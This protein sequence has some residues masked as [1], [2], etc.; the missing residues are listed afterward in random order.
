MFPEVQWGDGM[1]GL[2]WECL[3]LE[4]QGTNCAGKR[5]EPALREKWQLLLKNAVVSNMVPGELCQ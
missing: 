4:H 2:E 1:D 3:C 5:K